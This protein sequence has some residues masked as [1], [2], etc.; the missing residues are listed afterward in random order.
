[1]SECATRPRGDLIVKIISTDEDS[2]SRSLPLELFDDALGY[3]FTALFEGKYVD[4]FGATLTAPTVSMT[5]S[6]SEIAGAL[7][8]L[9]DV[10]M[11][12]VIA[13]IVRLA[14]TATSQAI[15]DAV[16]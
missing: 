2:E 12:Y 14:K 6:D 3:Y 7:S 16:S 11:D 4:R 5:I 8:V 9:V 13:T 1:M 15:R 10:I